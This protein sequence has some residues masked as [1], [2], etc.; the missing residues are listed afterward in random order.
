MALFVTV[1]IPN[2]SEL[3]VFGDLVSHQG[4][5]W[6]YYNYNTLVV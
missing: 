4:S 3:A 1:P 2:E 5:E 6:I